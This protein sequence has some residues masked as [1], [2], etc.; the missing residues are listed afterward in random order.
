MIQLDRRL[1]AALA[2]AA[3]ALAGCGSSKPSGVSPASYVK[4]VCTA[5]SSWKNAIEGAG[6]KLQSVAS[7]K[8]LSTTK[9]AYVSFVNSLAS[10][11]GVAKNQLA[12]AGTPSVS[13]GKS[14]SQTLVQVFG[15][16]KTNLDA[17]AAD[18]AK[19]PTT[20]KSAFSAA[21]NKVQT[22]VRNSLAGMS[23]ITPEKN[24]QLHT[25]AAK[26]PTCRSLASGT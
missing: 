23:R 4:S 14:I 19:I 12:A 5:A 8:S 2:A 6:V 16:A 11:T 17:A 22:D 7:S 1:V 10:A 15:Q 13:N 3:L 9:S 26:D 24:P 25:A 18:A 21:A 20:S